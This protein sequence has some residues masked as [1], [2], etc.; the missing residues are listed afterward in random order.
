MIYTTIYL[1]EELMKQIDNLA[2]KNEHSRSQL[3]RLA[4]KK[5]LKENGTK[6]SENP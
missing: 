3:I 1:S 6:R 5:Y 4:L 2:I